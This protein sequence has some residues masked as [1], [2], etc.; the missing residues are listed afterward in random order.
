[1]GSKDFNPDIGK[2]TQYRP[3]ESGNPAGKPKGALHLST[4]I[5]NLLNDPEFTTWVTDPK[6]GWKEY[7][8]APVKAIIRVLIIK[9]M[10]GDVKA[11]DALGKY[12]YGTKLQLSNDPENPVSAPAD[13]ALT[14]KW[15]EFLKNETHDG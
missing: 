8:G 13:P 2:N 7:T 5:Q 14:A 9:A 1:V 15:T 11:F 3:G 4:H 10:A 6:E 12:G